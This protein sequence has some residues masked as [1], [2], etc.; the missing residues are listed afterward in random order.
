MKSYPV[1]EDTYNNPVIRKVGNG[2]YVLYLSANYLVLSI[3]NIFNNV[4]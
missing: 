2:T 3:L 4:L 1:F